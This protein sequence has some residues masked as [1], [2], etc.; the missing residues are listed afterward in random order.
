MGIDLI[1]PSAQNGND[2]QKDL[3][4]QDE[5]KATVGKW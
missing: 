3:H 5:P 2:D 1:Y 4:L